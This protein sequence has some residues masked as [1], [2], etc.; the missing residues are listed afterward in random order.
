M[1][2]FRR[3]FL[4]RFKRSPGRYYMDVRL[5][6]ARV[7]LR[8]SALS[9]TDVADRVGFANAGSLSRAYRQRFGVVPSKDRIPK[10]G[11]EQRQPESG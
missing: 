1:R 2:R 11:S 5:G 4:R 6:R 9:V 7:L 3:L 10:T 8:N